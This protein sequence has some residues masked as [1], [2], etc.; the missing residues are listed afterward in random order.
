MVPFDR[1]KTITEES[2]GALLEQL[3]ECRTQI[4]RFAA[5]GCHMFFQS[6]AMFDS[7]VR[8]GVL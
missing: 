8:L 5:C 7:Y 3:R 6:R 2:I 4:F 1:T